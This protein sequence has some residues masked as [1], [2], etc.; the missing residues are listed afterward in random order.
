M[1]RETLKELLPS[2]KAVQRYREVIIFSAGQMKNSRPLVQHVYE[3]WIE[4]YL[5]DMRKS[6]HPLSLDDKLFQVSLC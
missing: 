1:F 2:L 4:E 6:D 3:M 5:N